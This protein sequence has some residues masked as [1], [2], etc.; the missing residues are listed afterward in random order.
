MLNPKMQYSSAGVA[1]TERFESCR[2]IAYQD[3]VGVWTIAYGHT[4]G[5]QPGMTCTPEQALQWL[6]EDYARC[7]DNVNQFVNVPLKQGEFDALVDFE[8]NL[9]TGSL[10]GSTLLK[11]LNAGNH[12]A[13]A[14]EFEKW[15]HAGGKVVAGLLRRRLAEETEFKAA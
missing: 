13:A 8:F 4:R 9:G 11:L 14:A 15:D 6:Q 12:E 7:V 2:Y 1:L 10:D 3:Q 5:V